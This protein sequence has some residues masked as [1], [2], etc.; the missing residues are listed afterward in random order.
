MLKR[1]QFGQKCERFE[2]DH[3][4]VML[5]FEADTIL[6]EQQHEKTKEKI[7]Y[8]RKRPNHHGR[9]KLPAHLPVEE[10]VSYQYNVTTYSQ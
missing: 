4:Q 6:V 2:G 8:I 9:A 10:I 3:N 7:E 1:I 5:P